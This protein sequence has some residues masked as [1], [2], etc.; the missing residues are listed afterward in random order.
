MKVAILAAL[1]GISL[2]TNFQKQTH[3]GAAVQVREEFFEW[4]KENILPSVD[5]IMNN[6]TSFIPSSVQLTD[7][8]ELKNIKIA[9]LKTD[10]SAAS[11]ELSHIYNGML[12]ELPK[13]LNWDIGLDFSYTIL[14]VFSL[15]GS[16]KL[17][18]RNLNLMTGL[19]IQDRSE[20]PGLALSKFNID[21]G[22]T[23]VELSGLFGVLD[24]LSSIINY[25]GSTFQFVLNTFGTMVVNMGLN[26]IVNPMLTGELDL[27]LTTGK[28]LAFDYLMPKK[29][30]FEPL[31]M[32]LSM[33]AAFGTNTY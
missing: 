29:P 12:V 25:M 1:L 31:A 23:Q 14:Y 15:D 9:N 20:A 3:P 8:L 19:E 5:V 33:D 11:V 28:T 6:L 27:P 30:S 2:G 22:D 17:P 21:L 10:I 18:V 13:V 16:I 26:A 24:Y 32:Q 4:G 7:S